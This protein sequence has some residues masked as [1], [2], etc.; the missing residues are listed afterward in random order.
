[1]AASVALVW[2]SLHRE[3]SLHRQQRNFLSAVTH[4]LKSPLASAR[5]YVESLQLG[6]VPDEK[7][8]RY[9]T[10][11]LEDMDR[12]RHKVDDL[13]QSARLASA[14]PKVEPERV[15]IISGAYDQL[16]TVK[17]GQRLADH[18]GTE[19]LTFPGGHIVQNRRAQAFRTALEGFAHGRLPG[20]RRGTERRGQ[21]PIRRRISGRIGRIHG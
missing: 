7:R 3:I 19:L 15:S 11:A 18:F 9:L 20:A 16:A 13:L 17:H 12:L 21:G 8:P 10:N 5:L 2:R 14:G 1:M 6:R 4:E